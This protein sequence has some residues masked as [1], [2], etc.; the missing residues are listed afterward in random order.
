MVE[1]RC[2]IIVVAAILLTVTGVWPWTEVWPVDDVAT[3]IKADPYNALT[4]F[5]P[6]VTMVPFWERSFYEV[7][8]PF[9]P[10]ILGQVGT[11]LGVA[12]WLWQLT[13]NAELRAERPPY[14]GLT[15]GP[16]SAATSAGTVGPLG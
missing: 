9:W 8:V 15:P 11:I 6:R 14:C 3:Y 16:Q 10:A 1:T 12:A 5:L 2:G 13:R 4:D 7:T